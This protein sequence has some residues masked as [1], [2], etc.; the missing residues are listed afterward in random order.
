MANPISPVRV[1]ETGCPVILEKPIAVT[2]AEAA[3][4]SMRIVAA[5]DEISRTGQTIN[6]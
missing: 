4:N 6:L 2:V 3:L 1:L 5:A